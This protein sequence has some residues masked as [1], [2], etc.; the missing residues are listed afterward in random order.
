M[1]PRPTDGL[2]AA[3]AR[4]DHIDRER[5]FERCWPTSETSPAFT[6]EKLFEQ[7][8]EAPVRYKAEL[9]SG[10]VFRNTELLRFDGNKIAEVDVYF[11]RTLKEASER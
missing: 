3:S 2:Q 1:R 11:G 7:G 6:M 10:K 8:N 9:N 5:Y 4:C